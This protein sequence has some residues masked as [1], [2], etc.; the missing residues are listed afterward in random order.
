MSSDF[1]SSLSLRIDGTQRL[2]SAVVQAVEAVCDLAE[3]HDGPGV[4]VARVNGA[5]AGCAWLEEA[6]VAAV[7]KWER[8]VRRLERSAL[9]TICLASGDCGGIALD[10]LLAADVRIATPDLHLI[11]ACDQ[12]ATWPGM[13]A[14]RLVH[15]AGTAAVR[16]AVLFGTPINASEALALR[17]VNEL[18][19]DPEAA[20]ATMMVTHS[21]GAELA[22]RRQLMFDAC[23]MSFEE[24]LGTHLAACDRAMRRSQ[25]EVVS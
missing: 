1:I 20:L 8:A 21:A 10:V 11:V 9:P 18:T 6:H 13:A 22:I 19:E 16:Q 14:F 7:S 5:P 2:S 24:A 3:S 4:I 17:L 25:G 15:Q 23:W 12:E